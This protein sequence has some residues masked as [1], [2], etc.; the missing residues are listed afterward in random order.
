MDSKTLIKLFLFF[1]NLV[2]SSLLA[3]DRY[4]LLASLLDSKEPH[5]ALQWSLGDALLAFLE[6]YGRVHDW[7][8]VNEVVADGGKAKAH[9]GQAFNIWRVVDAFRNTL[10][11]LQGQEVQETEFSP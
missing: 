7:E 2:F 11:A 9:F 10:H 8:K 1:G 3:L 4:V 6:Y 5:I